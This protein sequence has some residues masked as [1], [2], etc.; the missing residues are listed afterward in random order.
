M[1][2]AGATNR[3]GAQALV[4]RLRERRDEI[5][6]TLLT[7]VYAISDP[8]EV[9][10]P[11]YALGLRESV[12]AALE[13]GLSCMASSERSRPRVPDRLLLQARQAARAG[14][15]LDTVLRR[16]FA[17]YTLLEDFI[18][19]EVGK[20]EL[21]FDVE[22]HQQAR[23]RGQALDRLIEVISSE[24]EASTQGHLLRQR[25]AE[26]IEKLLAG[27]LVEE[28]DLDYP[29]DAWHLGIVV[30]GAICEEQIK[31]LGPALDRRTLILDR[32][33]EVK[34]IWLGGRRRL[35]STLV[36][37]YLQA[38]APQ[39]VSI[40]V[41]EPARGTTGWRLTNKQAR[42][43]LP[44]AMRSELGV[45]CYSDVCLLASSIGDEV[46][47]HSLRDLYVSPLKSHRGGRA[48]CTT[49]R[50]YFEAG[51]NISSTAAALDITRQ[52]VTNRLQVVEQ[53]LGR[54]LDSCSRELELALELVDLSL[55]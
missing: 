50:A 45:V 8:A 42:A 52:T 9:E 4:E 31:A 38:A 40:A 28:A 46:L 26:C 48:L 49:L 11:E 22:W 23:L 1:P 20:G 34:W 39:E 10:D 35:D 30:A 19:R 5:E 13:Y 53:E 51:E 14:V 33:E 15:S 21:A 29:L 2:V 27:E 25:H 43:A 54:S 36:A 44:I 17:G 55:V 24:Y 37:E 47:A 7:R 32:D 12:V 18:A 16:Y 3:Q 41:G 6:Q